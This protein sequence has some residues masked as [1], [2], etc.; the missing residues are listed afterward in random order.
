[1]TLIVSAT[2]DPTYRATLATLTGS[3]VI[4]NKTIIAIKEK[5]MLVGAAPTSTANFDIAI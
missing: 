4:E 2:I 3:Q 1:M 5:V